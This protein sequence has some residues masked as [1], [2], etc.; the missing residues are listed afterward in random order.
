MAITKERIRELIRQYD[1]HSDLHL[2]DLNFYATVTKIYME[3]GGVK[4]LSELSSR[5]PK[6]DELVWDLLADAERR[7]ISNEADI[8]I[9]EVLAEDGKPKV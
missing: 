2:G 1:E 9:R 3:H 7:R 8:L 5:N 6:S 4:W